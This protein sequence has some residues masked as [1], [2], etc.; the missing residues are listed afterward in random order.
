M[1]SDLNAIRLKVRRL[2][3]SPS[4]TQLSNDNIDE[5]VNTFILYDF[6]EHL[7]LFS[8]RKVFTFY[9]EPFIDEYTS[10]NPA[11]ELDDFENKYISVHEPVFIDGNRVPLY[12][13]RDQFYGIYPRVNTRQT[14][15]TGDGATLQ[16]TGTLTNFPILRNNVLFNSIAADYSSIQVHDPQGALDATA[17]LE[18]DGTGIINYVTGAY[19]VNFNTAPA[20]GEDVVVHYVPYNASVPQAVLFFD[21]KFYV[22]PV[23]DQAY[24]VDMEVYKRPTELLQTGSSP[25][26]EQWWQYIAYGAAK[27]VFEDR[28]DLGSV[29]Q[30]MPEFKQQ[31]RLILRKTLVQQ[32]NERVYTIYTDNIDAQNSSWWWNYRN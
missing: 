12:Q 16:F 8:L 27:K 29:Q 9:T 4:E 20:A 30:I 6:P 19:T 32:S 11:V 17:V 2:T 1:A 7:R 22:R 24:R 21:N 13:D 5:Y 18:G 15:G 28:M 31:E 23:P 14:I 26:L 25:E 3:R 10:E